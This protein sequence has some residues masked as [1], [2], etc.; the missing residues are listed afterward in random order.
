MGIEE[1]DVHAIG[2]E[3]HSIR[4]QQKTSQILRKRCHP[5]TRDF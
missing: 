5:G 1:E 2:I 3:T 4:Y